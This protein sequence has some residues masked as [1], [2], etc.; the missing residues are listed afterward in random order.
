MASPP[1]VQAA[2]QHVR[3]FVWDIS[4]PPL[5]RRIRDG[6]RTGVIGIGRERTLAT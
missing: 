5:R 6:V 1:H 4:A 3:M 2:C